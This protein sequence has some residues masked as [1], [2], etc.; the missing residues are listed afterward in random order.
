MCSGK[1]WYKFPGSRS[2]FTYLKEF[3]R[4]LQGPERQNTILLLKNRCHKQ[5]NQPNR[6]LSVSAGPRHSVECSNFHSNARYAYF[7]G[8]RKPQPH[9]FFCIFSNCKFRLFFLLAPYTLPLTIY[10]TDSLFH[11][12]QFGI[13]HVRIRSSLEEK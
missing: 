1:G 7:T 10:T 5:S 6:T 3:A 8:V 9:N 13:K 11:W 12:L 4:Q 2:N